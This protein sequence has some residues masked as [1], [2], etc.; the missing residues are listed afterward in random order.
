MKCLL[1]TLLP[2]FLYGQQIKDTI[3]VKND[4]SIYFETNEHI[5][6]EDDTVAIAEILSNIK[7]T[8]SY[9]YYVDAHTD[10]VGSKEANMLLS[11]KRKQSV[12]DFL[13]ARGIQDS[14]IT[15]NY[16]GEDVPI[17]KNNTQNSRQLN[18][19]AVFKVLAHKKLFKFNGVV[20]DED[21]EQQI[22]AK[23]EMRT[24][25]FSASTVTNKR[26]EYSMWGPL[27]EFVIL[28]ILAEGYFFKSKRIKVSRALID[29]VVELP[30]SKLEIG[31]K[32]EFENMLFQGNMAIILPMSQPQ[33][34][35]LRRFMILNKESCIEIAGHVNV[36][37]APV[38]LPGT[39]S[40]LLSSARAITIQD[41]LKKFG[42]SE[43]RMLSRGYGNLH[44]IYPKAKSPEQQQKNRRVEIIVSDCDSTK[45]IKDDYVPNMDIFLANAYY[46]FFNKEKFDQDT[47][48]FS[49]EQVINIILVVKEIEKAGKDPT[50]YTYRDMLMSYPEIPKKRTF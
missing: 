12:V 19:R 17:A 23:I 26:G 40:Y 18:R 35:Q 48:S 34:E 50:N 28:D 2:L 38:I 10:N 3:V 37:N 30:L 33:L 25:D 9:T 31:K 32:Y 43:D 5:L 15:S 42:V 46:R 24:K 29:R 27:G 7:D 1:L 14:L 22:P 39:R 6:S 49:K 11:E 20:V 45:I 21:S 44:M 41:E 36:P 4:Y 16:H 8:A 13:I 47:K